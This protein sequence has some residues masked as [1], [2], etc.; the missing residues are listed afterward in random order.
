MSHSI[1]DYLLTYLPHCRRLRRADEKADW[2]VVSFE[3]SV[4]KNVVGGGDDDKAK[5]ASKA[6]VT[7]SS[8]S[9][10]GGP[11]QTAAATDGDGDGAEVG[12]DESS[13]TKIV[14]LSTEIKPDGRKYTIKK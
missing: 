4:T 3:Y 6:D 12:D 1:K 5:A 13:G 14:R 11:D 7:T 2:D 9:E 8:S 10:G